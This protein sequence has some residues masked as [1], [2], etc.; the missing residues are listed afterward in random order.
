MEQNLLKTRRCKKI[1]N[2]ENSDTQIQ[3]LKQLMQMHTHRINRRNPDGG[4][5]RKT[6]DEICFN[7]NQKGHVN[8]KCRRQTMSA[9][10]L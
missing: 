9:Y 6:S 2:F 3:Q 1:Q 10:T 8:R 4:C 5:R 7:C